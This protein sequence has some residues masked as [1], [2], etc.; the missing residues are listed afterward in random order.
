MAS[1]RCLLPFHV[2]PAHHDIPVDDTRPL[3]IRSSQGMRRRYRGKID[4]VFVHVNRIHASERGCRC[5]GSSRPW[6]KGILDWKPAPNPQGP[7][8]GSESGQSKINSTKSMWTGRRR[9]SRRME[10]EMQALPR[11]C[12]APGVERQPQPSDFD[13]Q[14]QALGSG[15]VRLIFVAVTR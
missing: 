12:K 13:E 4:P 5:P 9:R 2:P 10:D 6:T 8:S 3:S 1:I 15:Q 7:E 11:Q 14:S